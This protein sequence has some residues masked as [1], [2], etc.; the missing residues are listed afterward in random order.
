[1]R[2]GPSRGSIVLCRLGEANEVLL[3]AGAE[4]GPA[5]SDARSGE[6]AEAIEVTLAAAP[7]CVAG[8]EKEFSVVPKEKCLKSGR[9]RGK[10]LREGTGATASWADTVKIATPSPIMGPEYRHTDEFQADFSLVCVSL[11]SHS[12]KYIWSSRVGALARRLATS[13][14]RSRARSGATFSSS[15][16]KAG[17]SPEMSTSATR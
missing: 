2:S 13:G 17:L 12:Q 15:R 4:G 3:G 8:S 7:S 16:S 5:W 14:S 10:P 11:N 9:S 6:T 1:M